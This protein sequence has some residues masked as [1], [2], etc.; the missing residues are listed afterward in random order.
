M[1]VPRLETAQRRLVISVAPQNNIYPH[2]NTYLK[3]AVGI[4][5]NRIVTLAI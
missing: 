4:T 3:K 5:K 1:V 2:S